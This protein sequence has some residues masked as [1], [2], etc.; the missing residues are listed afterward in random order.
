MVTHTDNVSVCRTWTL[1]VLCKC[2]WSALGVFWECSWSA[3]GVRWECAGNALGMRK[4]VLLLQSRYYGAS[5]V[6]RQRL[7]Q[8]P[9]VQA[10]ASRVCCAGNPFSSVAT[11]ALCRPLDLFATWRWRCWWP[12]QTWAL[13]PIDLTSGTAEERE[14]ALL[15]ARLQI[16][17]GRAHTPRVVVMPHWG[18]EYSVHPDPLQ[19]KLAARLHA[20]GA[21]LVIG[22]HSHVVQDR[23]C[24][25]ATA[26]YYGLGN[27]LFDGPQTTWQGLLVRCCAASGSL[28]C[29]P[30]ATHRTADL[31]FPRIDGAIAGERCQLPLPQPEPAE[32]L[33]R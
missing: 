4:E 17:L 8:R 9:L 23:R 7:G 33:S 29:T 32:G 18:R 22:S 13:V 27:H 31:V 11:G 14:Q 16:G 30:L 12:W 24:S 25:G 2:S 1:G 15:R 19:E 5:G 20:W 21:L 28:D 6:Q 26:T 3:L 10:S